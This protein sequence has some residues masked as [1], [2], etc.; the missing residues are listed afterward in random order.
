MA[1]KT[2]TGFKVPCP[3]CGAIGSEEDDGLTIEVGTLTL[4][5]SACSE[6]VTVRDLQAMVDDAQRLIRWLAAAE[7]V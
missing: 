4:K 3:H 6:E 1:T 2:A 5:C 7:T